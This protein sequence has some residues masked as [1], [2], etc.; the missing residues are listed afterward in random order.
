[1]P[2]RS[3]LLVPLLALGCG[4]ADRPT[5]PAAGPAPGA[6]GAPSPGWVEVYDPARAWNGYTLTLHATRVPV[7]LDMNGR[8]VHSWP[9][10]RLKSRV[11]L[12]PDGSILGLGL[13]R[14]VVEYDWEGRRR[15]E[16]RTPGAIPHHDAIRLRN[17][18]TLVLVLEEGRGTTPCSRSTAPA[19]W[20]GAGSRRRASG[21]A[22]P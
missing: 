7:L 20:C 6:A 12:L 2:W 5:P 15:W 8:V 16:F 4:P 14:Q 18:D 1:M 21:A 10:A 11:R 13:G 9:E 17:G 22:S 19:R 3:F